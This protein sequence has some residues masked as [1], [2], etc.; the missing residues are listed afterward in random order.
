M[1]RSRRSF[2]LSRSLIS[3][4]ILCGVTLGDAPAHRG[5]GSGDLLDLPHLRLPE[6]R[7]EHDPPPTRDVVADALPLAAQ[8]E[9]QLAEL[10]RSCRVYGSSGGRL[11]PAP[12]RCRRPRDRTPGPSGPGATPGPPAQAL[13]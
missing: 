1:R 10:P 4:S 3:A 11:A 13:R 9:A 7:Q 2:Q 8:V 12:G 5:L 6:D